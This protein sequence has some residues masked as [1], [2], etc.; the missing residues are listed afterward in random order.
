[1]ALLNGFIKT[2]AGSGSGDYNTYFNK[3]SYP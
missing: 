2:P 3:P 1:M